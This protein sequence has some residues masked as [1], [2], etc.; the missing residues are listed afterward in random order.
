LGGRRRGRARAVS[1]YLTL[2]TPSAKARVTAVV[3]YAPEGFDVSAL[4][5][6]HAPQGFRYLHGRP[7]EELPVEIVGRADLITDVY[8]PL[9]YT[10]QI[11]GLMEHYGRLLKEGGRLWAVLPAIT[12][13]NDA[14]R[15][16]P[17]AMW[18]AR[19]RGF[20]PLRLPVT[21]LPGLELV[22]VRTD[23]P[24]QVPRL[25][26]NRVAAGAPP[27]REYLLLG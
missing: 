1:E 24:V 25:F 22:M 13:V 15:E 12:V 3:L 21:G 6:A 10:R 11:D 23:E 20:R 18:F 16:L 4:E 26:L 17:L 14:D 27:L 8:G 19:I 7:I 2:P 9:Q 5:R